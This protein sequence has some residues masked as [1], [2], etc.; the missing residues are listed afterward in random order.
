[1]TRV[2]Y[3][4]LSFGILTSC[5]T[6]DALKSSSDPYRDYVDDKILKSVNFDSGRQNVV[7]K[8]LEGTQELKDKQEELAPCF[9]FEKKSE[10]YQIILAINL[11]HPGSFIK[12]DLKISLNGQEPYR[13]KEIV[14][15]PLLETLYYYAYP[16]QRVFLVDFSTEGLIN[17]SYEKEFRVKTPRGEVLIKIP[18]A[19]N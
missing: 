4:L 9:G 6:V 18:K 3:F 14:G 17:S 13:L 7:V 12:G 8:I 16:Y 19:E 2:L 5:A 10:F 1:M 15:S 11:S